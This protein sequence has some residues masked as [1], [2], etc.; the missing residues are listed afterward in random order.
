MTRPP[1]HRQASADLRGAMDLLRTKGD[2]V[3]AL[4]IPRKW[5]ATCEKCRFA[6]AAIGTFP[7]FVQG[8][9]GKGWRVIQLP[10]LKGEP[11]ALTFCPACEAK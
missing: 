8:L 2:Q 10:A 1:P 3:Q 6:V 4:G 11:N 9:Q 5:T 7:A